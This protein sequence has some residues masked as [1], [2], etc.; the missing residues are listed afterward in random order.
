MRLEQPRT[1]VVGVGEVGGALAEILERVEPV[2]RL[3][4]QPEEFA[5]P[6]GVMHLCFPYRSRAQFVEAA[7]GYIE[8]FKPKLT[9]V[10][11]TVVPGTVRAIVAR[12]GTRVA[13]SPIRGKHARM[14]QEVL[15]YTKYI[16]ALEPETSRLAAE[17]FQAAGMKTRTFVR[18]ETLELAKLAE[19][20]Y[21]GV[22]IAFAQELNRLANQVDGDYSEI[23]EFF[24]EVD[25]LPRTHYYPGFIGGHCVIPN[26]ELLKEVAPSILFEAVLS[27]NRLRAAE[28]GNEENG[29]GASHLN[30]Q[31]HEAAGRTSV[32]HT[33][34]ER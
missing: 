19:T 16:A 24:D 14:V 8:R 4:L 20:S 1:L 30:A 11:S 34:R 26:L 9:I 10:N 22:L 25:F 29:A 21:F 6:I 31:D 15:Y 12:T 33:G 3:D 5:H 17:H 28:L 32:N 18:P 13:Y 7:S 27:S 2:L 23:I